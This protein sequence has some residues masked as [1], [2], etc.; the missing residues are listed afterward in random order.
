[1]GRHDLLELVMYL[2]LICTCSIFVFSLIL[3]GNSRGTE[4]AGAL[5]PITIRDALLLTEENNPQLRAI[6]LGLL[7]F[8]GRKQQAEMRPVTDLVFETENF[9]GS[10]DLKGI[11]G[12]EFTLALSQLV[13]LGDKRELRSGVVGAQ[14]QLFQSELERERLDIAAEVLNRFLQV[15]ADQKRI[16]LTRQAQELVQRNLNAVSERVDAALAPEAELHRARADFERIRTMAELALLAQS[17]SM[18]WLAAM[19]AD[20][21]NRYSVVVTDLFQLPDLIEFESVISMLD[22]SPMAKVLMDTASLHQAELQLVQSRSQ[23]DLSFSGGIRRFESTNDNALVFSLSV[24]L[25]T[26]KRNSGALSEA[27]AQLDQIK[28]TSGA[29]MTNARSLLTRYYSELTEVRIEFESSRDRVMPQLEAALQGTEIAYELGRYGLLELVDAQRRLLNVQM[30]LIDAAARY[31]E[32]LT[33]IESL[34]GQPVAVA[35][36]SSGDSL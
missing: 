23:R 34:T 2:R 16:E 27:R 13:E 29:T 3:T 4:P 1:M 33:N 12:A 11:G 18:N 14:K 28:A 9:L 6:R 36:S 21:P 26:T 22:Q 10:G 25:K 32:L 31:H 5:P 30:E 15:A 35:A 17:R 7:K 8:E 20:E 24:P 19:W